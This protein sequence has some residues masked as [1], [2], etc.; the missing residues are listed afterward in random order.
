[1]NPPDLSSR[2]ANAVTTF[3]PGATVTNASPLL[4][5]NSAH[6]TAVDVTFRDCSS[7]RFVVRLPSDYRRGHH[8]NVA[9]R[10]FTVIRTMHAAGIHVQTPVFLEPQT[11][12]NPAP[13]YLVE[14]C[15]GR[16]ELGPRDVEDYLDQY[17]TRLAGSPDRLARGRAFV[18]RRDRIRLAGEAGEG[19]HA[20]ARG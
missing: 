1:M 12:H 14:Y 15:E 5:G 18:P 11:T 17:A 9:E 10:E 20:D 7:K 4:G 19:A 13:F 2:I 16:P 3:A 6:V 8:A